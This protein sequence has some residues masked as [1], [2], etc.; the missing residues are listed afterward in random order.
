MISGGLTEGNE[1]SGDL[2]SSSVEIYDPSAPS[3]TRSCQITPNMPTTRS[4]I[5]AHGSLVCGDWNGH[6]RDCIELRDGAWQTAHTLNQD[7]KWYNSI[8]HQPTQKVLNVHYRSSTWDSSKGLVIMAGQG[9]NT[10][11][12]I[13]RDD[14]TSDPYFNLTEKRL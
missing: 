4:S 11:T 3:V 8:L 1:F 10:T 6:P 2:R 14:L 13:L 7:R 5:V 9:A 12:E